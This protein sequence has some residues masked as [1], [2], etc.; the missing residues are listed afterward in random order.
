MRRSDGL[1]LRKIGSRYMIVS[2]AENN[3]NLSEVYT[4]NATA[5]GI[6]ER[7]EE[8][9][10]EEIADWICGEYEV[11]R[12]RALADVEAQLEEWEKFGLITR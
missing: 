5:A 10:V 2:L 1:K 4:L 6:W 7:V 8:N 3:V 12:E 9:T 11:D